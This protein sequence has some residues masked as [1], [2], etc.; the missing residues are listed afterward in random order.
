MRSEL[1][2]RYAA[3]NQALRSAVGT[4]A[5][6]LIK[7]RAGSGWALSGPYLDLPAGQCRVR[8]LLAQPARGAIRVELTSN[9]GQRTIASEKI[10]FLLRS[11]TVIELAA[12]LAETTTGIEV[13]I[14]CRSDVSLDIEAVEID[15][16]RE[17]PDEPLRADRTVGFETSKTYADKIESGFFGRYLSGPAVME[18]GYKGYDG[19]TVPIVPQAVG[20]D[21]DYP[22]YDGETFPFA[23]ASFDAIY[24]SHCYEHIG[25][26][27][28]VLQDWY[29]MLRIGG[30]LI[31]VVPH[32]LLFERKR[33]LP[34]YFNPDHK[35]YYTSKSLLGEIEE[36]LV[37]NGYRI[38]HLVENDKGFDFA[39][40]PREGSSGCYE[41]E[42]VI[43]KVAL[44]Y[45]HP[46]DGTVRAYPAGE[47]R[48]AMSHSDPWRID[49]D[50]TQRDRCV[51]Y[52]PYIALAPARYV[53]DFHFENAD[54]AS[55][56]APPTLFVDVARMGEQIAFR[57]LS[58]EEMAGILRDGKVSIDFS[59]DVS[60]GIYEF[61][62]FAG[63]PSDYKLRFKGVDLRYARLPRA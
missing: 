16:D 5:D 61:R 27:K 48:S 42:L 31:I 21:V 3:D 37:E 44:P 32:Q 28:A 6:G 14:A 9:D 62:V 24:S 23:D 55:G 46:D 54:P 38:R 12:N 19:G 13:R 35:R 26:W 53:A 57:R 49:L 11:A 33:H 40:S 59:N 52:G 43:E 10:N 63:M 36:A 47:F 18:I 20:V 60:G 50:L 56:I 25:P 39:P 17:L 41:I 51:I 7:V 29:R 2:W 1:R 15:L 58:S 22:G 4:R 8:V 45:W 30:F 34:S